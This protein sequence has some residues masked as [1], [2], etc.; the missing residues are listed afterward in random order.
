MWWQMLT[1]TLTS[2]AAF[3]A[4]MAL[5]PVPAIRSFG[6]LSA[7]ALSLTY[8]LVLSLFSA[9]LVLSVR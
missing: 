6:C 3:V 2:V 8:V 1:T 5:S 4:T 9:C 7:V